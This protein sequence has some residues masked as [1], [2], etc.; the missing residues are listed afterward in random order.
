MAEEKI[1][2]IRIRGSIGVKQEILD[3]LKMLNL[4]KKHNCVVVPNT[5]VYKGMLVKCKDYIT[6][7]EIDAETEKELQEKRGKE[8]QKYYSLHPPKGGFER[9]G[10]KV[11]FSR[12]GVLGYRGAKINELVQ[13]ML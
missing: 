4:T 6:Y 13:K 7:G 10:I 2:I 12:K 1:A 9:K 3:T 11:P 5:P 8:G